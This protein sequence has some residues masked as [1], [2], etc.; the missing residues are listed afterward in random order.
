MC[1]P[2]AAAR[3]ISSTSC[4]SPCHA[5]ARTDRHPDPTPSP[6]PTATPDADSETR[7][8]T[9]ATER[10]SGRDRYDEPRLVRT[11]K[12]ANLQKARQFR[13]GE[14]AADTALTAIGEV[15]RTANSGC[16]SKRKNNKGGYMLAELVRQVK[17]VGQIPVTEGDCPTKRATSSKR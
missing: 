5:D 9:A 11:L 16:T 15:K 6:E 13:L 14:I 4:S 17:P 8:P 3:A 12:R 2:K 7:R 1:A 10:R